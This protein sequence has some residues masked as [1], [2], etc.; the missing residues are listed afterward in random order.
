MQKQLDPR[1]FW[2]FF[3]NSIFSFF[4][5]VFAL[6]F[7]SFVFVENTGFPSLGVWAWLFLVIALPI[8]CAWIYAT[9]TLKFYRYEL[10]EDGFRKESGI[11]WKRYTTIPYE[12]IQNVDIHRGIIAR[13]FG[14]SDLMVQTAGAPAVQN[15]WGMAEGRLPGIDKNEAESLR[16]EL[17][18]RARNSRGQGL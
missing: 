4:F 9:L 15:S 16:D 12:R 2:I 11:I 6:G 13:V 3:I 14:L 17:V 10:R 18:R 7:Y 1:A 8:A 5:V